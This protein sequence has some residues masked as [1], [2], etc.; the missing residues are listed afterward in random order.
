MGGR[1]KTRCDYCNA[2]PDLWLWYTTYLAYRGPYR[3]SGVL[4]MNAATC[5]A[6]ESS[7]N[8]QSLLAL[9]ADGRLERKAA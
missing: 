3:L 2:A 9:H 7:V 1:R 6:H 8:W 5:A 4:S